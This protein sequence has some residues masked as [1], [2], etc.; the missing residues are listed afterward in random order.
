MLLPLFL[1]VL[2]FFFFHLFLNFLSLGVCWLSVFQ[3]SAIPLCT[4]SGFMAN[5]YNQY[6]FIQ[7][8]LKLTCLFFCFHFNC[9]VLNIGIYETT[10]LTTE[11]WYSF[12]TYTQ[13]CNYDNQKKSCANY[14]IPGAIRSM[15]PA[16]DT[17]DCLTVSGIV[18]M[19]GM[20]MSAL[21]GT[22]GNSPM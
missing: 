19:M 12:Y 6:W 21:F 18:L 1:S 8:F 11:L 20:S 3:M 4:S 14:I 15:A 16:Q 22:A 9:R 7:Y 17:W 5:N 2:L 13:I 10:N